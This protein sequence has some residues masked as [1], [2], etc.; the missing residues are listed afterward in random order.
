M[1][2]NTLFVE[3]SVRVYEG[4]IHSSFHANIRNGLSG[5]GSRKAVCDQI[6]LDAKMGQRLLDA[7]KDDKGKFVFDVLEAHSVGYAGL[8]DKQEVLE[9][10]A[11]IYRDL[12]SRMAIAMKGAKHFKSILGDAV[13]AYHRQQG[14][15][16]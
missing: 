16:G 11:T 6:D 1:L 15:T 5:E 14:I 8:G 13:T 4:V 12:C 10:R 2:N 9:A 7:H 3:E